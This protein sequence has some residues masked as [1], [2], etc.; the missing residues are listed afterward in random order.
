MQ[1]PCI[2]INGTDPEN[3]LTDYIKAKQALQVAAEALSAVWPHGRDYQTLQYGAH[4]RAADEHA[5]R[6]IK[7]REVIAEIETIAEYLV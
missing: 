7:V 2:N 5:A 4:Q 3:L 1:L 6:I